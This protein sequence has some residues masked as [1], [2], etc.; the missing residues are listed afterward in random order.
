MIK[1]GM[2]RTWSQVGH[3]LLL[4]EKTGYWRADATSF[5]RWIIDNANHFKVGPTVLWAHLRMVRYYNNSMYREL[6]GWGLSAPEDVRDLPEHV[7]CELLETYSKIANVA[8]EDVKRPLAIKVFEG[9]ARR[10]ELRAAWQAY[11][12]QG[13]L[14]P[15]KLGRISADNLAMV[16]QN[17]TKTFDAKLLTALASDK[18]WCNKEQNKPPIFHKIVQQVVVRPFDI[19][20]N[21]KTQGNAKQKE[22]CYD[23]AILIRCSDDRLQIHGI[24]ILRSNLPNYEQLLEKRKY[25]NHYWLALPEDFDNR[26]SDR[27]PRQVG[28]V[29]VDGT[30][31]M[32]VFG[33]QDKVAEDSDLLEMA[34]SLLEK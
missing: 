22:Y 2:Y 28:R 23:I 20:Q 14:K 21:K 11:R 31:I 24:D 27:I 25:V 9:T 33:E 26:L 30:T 18:G 5:S 17:A 6:C 8:P 16:R 4:I 34:R 10:S 12:N 3:L 29:M 7:K 15:G 19:K 13:T 1:S 32:P